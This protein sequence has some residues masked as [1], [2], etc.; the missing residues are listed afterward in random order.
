MTAPTEPTEPTE[1]PPRSPQT[2]DT[3]EALEQAETSL[4]PLLAGILLAA[5]AAEST[6]GGNSGD[7]EDGLSG[8]I[9]RGALFTPAWVAK[10]AAIGMTETVRG[11][12]LMVL[13]PLVLARLRKMAIERE[14]TGQLSLFDDLDLIAR[15]QTTESVD[16]VAR[17]L[18]TYSRTPRANSPTADIYTLFDQ[19]PDNDPRSNPQ[20]RA[21]SFATRTA[22]WVTRDSIFGAQEK[23]ARRYGYTHK[24][25]VSEQDNRVRHEHNY[26]NGK[27]VPIGRTFRTATGNIKY[28]GDITAP[29]HL[30]LNCRCS[31]EWLSR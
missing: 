20:R 12:I 24:R 3:E 28:P 10:T 7:I 6:N 22:R 11:L 26:L 17:G 13:H 2:V 18:D 16:K 8:V 1:Q 9:A 29:P 14:H 4:A 15:E 27:V 5:A 30:V 31:L 25:W 21:E 19:G 23:V